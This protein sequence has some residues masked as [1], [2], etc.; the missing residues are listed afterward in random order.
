MS[1]RP[2]KFLKLDQTIKHSGGP[3]PTMTDIKT[4]L[5]TAF[6]Y[7]GT[8]RGLLS[9]SKPELR[10][11]LRD[12]GI[13]VHFKDGRVVINKYDING[14]KTDSVSLKRD[15]KGKPTKTAVDQ[16]GKISGVKTTQLKSRLE[17]EADLRKRMR[18]RR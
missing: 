15:D 2:G 7:F 9:L 10:K 6:T 18:E 4:A 16:D 8:I 11:Q 5:K 1:E 12:R 3:K 14:K 13:M 17:T